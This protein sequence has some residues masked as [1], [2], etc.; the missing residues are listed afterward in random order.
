MT[1]LIYIYLMTVYM[2]CD[3]NQMP[4]VQLYSCFIH[5]ISTVF[6]SNCHT[7]V[8]VG[9]VYTLLGIVYRQCHI[10]AYLQHQF[11]GVHIISARFYGCYPFLWNWDE[12]HSAS[13]HQVILFGDNMSSKLYSLYLSHKATLLCINHMLFT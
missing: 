2:Y 11:L 3:Y 5:H 12:L 9:L 7:S 1:A 4:Y 6:L 10:A 8:V 13:L